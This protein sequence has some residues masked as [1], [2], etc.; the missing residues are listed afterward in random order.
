MPAHH[1]FIQFA[2]ILCENLYISVLCVCVV[3]V[4]L[5]ST[6]VLQ[7]HKNIEHTSC[8]LDLSMHEQNRSSCFLLY[9]SCSLINSLTN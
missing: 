4:Y 2:S 5:C 6:V 9:G 1:P 3:P 8:S 7:K